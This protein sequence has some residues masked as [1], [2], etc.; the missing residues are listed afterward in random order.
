MTALA[1]TPQA[2]TAFA[3]PRVLLEVTGSPSPPVNAYTSNFN[4]TA[5]G[6]TGSGTGVAGSLNGGD[7]YLTLQ[8]VLAVQTVGIAISA[9]RTVTGLTIGATYRLRVTVARS[10]ANSGNTRIRFGT[11]TGAYVALP[12]TAAPPTSGTVLE[13]TFTATATSHAIGVDQQRTNAG[14]MQKVYILAAT[15]APVATWQGT[16]IRRTDVNGNSVVV[17][18]DQGGM[19]T[20]AGVMTLYDLEAALCGP[21]GYAVTD[22]NGA[23]TYA[24]C[25]FSTGARF[26]YL[27]NP[28]AVVSAVGWFSSGTGTTTPVRYVSPGGLTLIRVLTGTGSSSGMS[29]FTSL[30][31][32]AGGRY[33]ARLRVQATDP[34]DFRITMQWLDAASAVITS[35]AVTVTGIAANAFATLS[36]DQ[37][38]PA[39]AVQCRLF[40]Q[41]VNSS[42]AGVIMQVEDALFRPLAV[43]ETFDPAEYFDGSTAATT[44]ELYGW[45]GAPHLS[46][47]MATA[48]TETTAGVWVSLPATAT[49]SAGT[50]TGLAV[51]MVLDYEEASQ[52]NG[53]LHTIIGRADPIANPGPLSLRTGTL[54]LYCADYVAA[55]A[56]RA[57][58]SAGDVAQV[59][60]PTHPGLDLYFVA[61]RVTLAPDETA[62]A[63]RRWVATVDYAEVLAA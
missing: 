14:T 38:A 54:E 52:S 22:G 59:R 20:A 11:A 12:V 47:S 6:W 26:N 3:P 10:D 21:V 24:A 49:P 57:L 25:S 43:G 23:V 36:I 50:V 17:R 7:P 15:V 48:R 32:V 2:G 37:V 16:T 5:D 28:S 44:T 1:A 35:P 29:Q 45:L 8:S 46:P 4:S 13:L 51:A 19:D 30:P 61:Q 31:I 55:K 40:V 60:Q 39:G 18:E 53:S 41:R 34:S 42:T 9:D 62:T 58:L 56:V 33:G 27:A 63:P